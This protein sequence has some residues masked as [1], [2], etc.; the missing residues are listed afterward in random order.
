[1][2]PEIDH[3]IVSTD[4]EEIATAARKHGGDVPFLRPEELARDYTPMLPVLKHALRECET[5]DGRHYESLL[6]LDPTS[7][8]RLP[9]DVSGALAMLENDSNACGVVAVSE[10]HFNPRWVCVEEQD[11]Y[12]R[13]AFTQGKQYTRR[14]DVAPV[15]RI[16]A[17]LYLWKCDYI[18][19][20]EKLDFG[21]APHLLWKVPE[22]RAVHIDELHDFELGE[23]LVT[24]GIVRLPWL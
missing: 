4:S 2:C 6:L 15:Y 13:M 21:E 23:L 16:N 24:N 7:P 5:R 17:L 18:R 8:G 22:Q 3:S 10:P 14:Q 19:S 20:A 12:A 9:E 1:M 11:G